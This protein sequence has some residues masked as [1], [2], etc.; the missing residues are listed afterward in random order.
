MKT[1]FIGQTVFGGNVDE[2]VGLALV[3]NFA[4]IDKG[5]PIRRVLNEADAEKL[6]KKLAPGV[7]VSQRRSV[8]RYLPELSYLPSEAETSSNRN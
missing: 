3:D 6:M 2:Y 4:D 7:V 5:P 8:V 1:L